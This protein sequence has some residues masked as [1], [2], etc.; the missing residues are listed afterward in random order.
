[1][2]IAVYDLTIGTMTPM[3]KNLDRI[4]RKAEEWV[5]DREIEPDAIL[6]AR[7]APD[8]LTLIHQVRIAT[9]IG[10]GAAARLSGLDVPVWADNESTFA[11]LHARIAK[12]LDYFGKFEPAQF[13][14][15]ESRTISL[16]TPFGPLEMPGKQYATHFVLP[17]FFF[18]VTTAYNIL[19]H[20]GLQI[21]KLDYIAG[22]KW[23]G[24][25]S[26]KD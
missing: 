2:S 21:G 9:D 26:K 24:D 18:H 23:P 19:R 4:I 15:A 25:P 7:L 14:G 11:D 22:G 5:S 13:E 6:S 20:N 1:M 17:N 12:G 16:K 8:M 10:K 3:L